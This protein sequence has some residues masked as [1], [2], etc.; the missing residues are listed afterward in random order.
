MSQTM[1]PGERFGT[2]TVV[3][4]A[5]HNKFHHPLYVARCDCGD[6]RTYPGSYIRECHRCAVCYQNNR[7]L[8]AK[9]YAPKER[10]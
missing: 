1:Q 10:Q 8:N 6:E 5:G 3:C 7:R 9:K 2:R 4:S